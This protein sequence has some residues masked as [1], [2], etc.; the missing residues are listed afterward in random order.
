MEI[1]KIA[2]AAAGDQDLGADPVGMVEQQDFP[3][4]LAGRERAHESRRTGAQDDDVERL[5]CPGHCR[6]ALLPVTGM[7]TVERAGQ[8]NG[9]SRPDF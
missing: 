4:A 5:R 2:A 7:A 8:R 9:D 3:A 6:F 1:G